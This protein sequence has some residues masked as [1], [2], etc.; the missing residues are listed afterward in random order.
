MVSS[1]PFNL[2]VR[3]PSKELKPRCREKRIEATRVRGSLVFD[4]ER[5]FR[6]ARTLG[7]RRWFEPRMF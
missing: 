7:Y 4:R 2:V 3:S 5:S 1:N 6:R